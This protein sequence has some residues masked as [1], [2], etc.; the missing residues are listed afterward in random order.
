MYSNNFLVQ[1]LDEFI[2]CNCN[3]AILLSSGKEYENKG[4]A[5]I[6]LCDNDNNFI[7]YENDTSLALIRL[8]C[9]Q[10][11]TRTK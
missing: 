11:I 3:F 6:N 1:Q 8:D 5:K 2:K 4:T 10:A 9:I 7:T